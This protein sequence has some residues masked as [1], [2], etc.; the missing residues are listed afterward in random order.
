MME[1]EEAAK[2]GYD[3]ISYAKYPPIQDYLK[4]AN[5]QLLEAAALRY[6]KMLEDIGLTSGKVFC[7]AHVNL[8]LF[9][10][11]TNPLAGTYA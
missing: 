10:R 8:V 1:R 11:T 2:T 7:M 5:G 3:L 4:Q 6:Q 9:F